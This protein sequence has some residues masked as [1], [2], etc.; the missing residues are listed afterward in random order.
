MGGAQPSLHGPTLFFSRPFGESPA[1]PW[2]SRLVLNAVPIRGVLHL[3][4]SRFVLQD[5][6]FR[7]GWGTWSIKFAWFLRS[8]CD[9]FHLQCVLCHLALGRKQLCPHP[10]KCQEPFLSLPSRIS[11]PPHLHLNLYVQAGQK[12]G[13]RQRHFSLP[14]SLPMLLLL[15]RDGVIRSGLRV[16]QEGTILPL[17]EELSQTLGPAA[18]HQSVWEESRSLCLT[19][20]PALPLEPPRSLTGCPLA[21]FRRLSSPRGWD[22]KT[23]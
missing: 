16:P 3:I 23:W 9:P 5:T 14:P 21:R 6:Q 8:T 10:G 20:E 17:G 19:A 4:F 18:I 11:P 2:F 22:L 1:Q 7:L 13:Q 12:W 15:F